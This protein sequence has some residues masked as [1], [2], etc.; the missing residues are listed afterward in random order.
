[1]NRRNF[2][3][4]SGKILALAGLAGLPHRGL[5]GNLLLKGTQDQ[6]DRSND[7]MLYRTLGKTGIRM[8]IVSMGVMN[9]SNPSLLKA[10][11]DAGIRFFDT[12]W[13]YQKGNNEKMVGSVL[14]EVGAKRED[15]TIATKIKLGTD[16]KG[17][18]AKE[19]FLKRFDESLSRLQT[20]YVDIL[21]YHDVKNLEQINDPYI[22][23]AFSELK[24]KGKI[25][26]SGFSIHI[27]WPDMVKDA[28]REKFY[29]VILLSY[30]YSMY[31]DQRVAD[32][33]KQ[34]HDAGI[35]LIAMKTQCQ[36]DWY[37]RNLPSDQK[38]FYGEKNMN[39][40]L[41]K[42][43]LHNEKITTAVPGFTNFDQLNEDMTVAYNLEYTKEE[44][45]FLIDR[46]VKLS[47]QSVC[48]QCGTCTASCPGNADIPNL[49][50]THMYSMNYGN[51]LM[52]RMTLD[53]I[54]PGKGIEACSN[55]AE[56]TSRCKYQVPIRE[57]INDLVEIYG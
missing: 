26:F 50:R 39:T 11:W 7:E 25:R 23:E 4:N 48:R 24:E 9:A 20:D 40:A 44:K 33:I 15:V 38:S 54:E 27:D 12:A 31:D 21:H 13:V 56:C 47:I 10:A 1:M 29:D 51:P 42:W 19:L 45:E 43:V 5:A 46:N 53:E 3:G 41:L 18:E 36:Q 55:C 17:K 57:R 37:K 8:P 16:I 30:N 2:L 34:A 52:A 32:A 49:M 35:G 14:Q 6:Q 22:R 28:A